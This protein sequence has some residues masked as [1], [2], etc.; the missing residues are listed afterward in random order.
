MERKEPLRLNFRVS[1]T[2]RENTYS[3]KEVWKFSFDGDEIPTSQDPVTYIK[4]RIREEIDRMNS[5]RPLVNI[6]QPDEPL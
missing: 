1:V 5:K 2:E 6:I 4:Q 3:D